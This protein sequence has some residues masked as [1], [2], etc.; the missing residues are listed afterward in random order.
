MHFLPDVW[1][2]CD[3]CRGQRYN[4]ETLA[5]TYRGKSIANV[6]AM[7]IGQ[8]LELFDNIPK[9]RAPLSVLAA[10]GLDYLTLGLART[11]GER[12]GGES[13]ASE[14]GGGTVSPANG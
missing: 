3:V 11:R 14:T 10:I 9:I 12:S 8:A 4:A 1:V 7:S 13:L 5:V 6:L 2:E